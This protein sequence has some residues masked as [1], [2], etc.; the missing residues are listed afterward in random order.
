[1]QFWYWHLHSFFIRLFVGLIR[2]NS[3]QI[4]LRCNVRCLTITDTNTN[5]KRPEHVYAIWI[6]SLIY[7]FLHS[8]NSSVGMMKKPTHTFSQCES[9]LCEQKISSSS[10][11]KSFDMKKYVLNLFGLLLLI[12]RQDDWCHR[13][14]L[15]NAIQTIRSSNLIVDVLNGVNINIIRIQDMFYSSVF[16]PFALNCQSFF[17]F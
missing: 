9:Q 12:V 6:Y 1:M 15:K 11:A 7:W 10:H 14:W 16:H 2:I 17:W 4:A 13:F 3:I 5:S 8:Q